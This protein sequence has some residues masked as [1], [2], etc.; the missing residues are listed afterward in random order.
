MRLGY[1]LSHDRI[2]LDRIR[3]GNVALFFLLVG[4]FYG[5]VSLQIFFGQEVN[6]YTGFCPIRVNRSITMFECMYVCT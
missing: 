1:V 4:C 6:K 3:S 5:K 2:G